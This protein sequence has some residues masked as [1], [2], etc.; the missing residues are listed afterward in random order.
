M[1]SFVV[2]DDK[3]PIESWPLRHAHLIGKESIPVVAKVEVEDGR[4]VCRKPTADEAALSLQFDAGP[5]G[6]LTLQTCLL[7]DR[8]R[9]Y[10]LELELAR[11]RIM[12][13]LNKLEEWSLADLPGDHPV[14]VKFD[15]AR[16][17]FSA[18]LTSPQTD[19]KYDVEHARLAREALTRAI[20][21]SEML[22]MLQAERQLAS[23]LNPEDDARHISSPRVGSIV[24]ND[25]F[26]DP[27]KRVVASHFDFITSPMRWRDIEKEEG[28]FSFGE[29]DRWIE[30]AVRSGKV[31]LTG[32][33]VLDFSPRATPDWLY[34]W[35]HDYSSLREFAYEHAKRVVTRYRRT[36][37]RWSVISGVNLN[38][39]FA[40]SIDQMLELTRL[41]VLLV[42]KLH[43]S[44][45]VVVELTQ[46]FGEHASANAQSV[47][48]LLYAELVMESG[49]QIDAFGLRLQF[50]DRTEG[51]STRDLMQFSAILD[52]YSVFEKPIDITAVGV[53]SEP[54]PKPDD[55]EIDMSPGWWHA[56]WSLELQSE[57]MTEA[58]TIA[59]GKPFVR[60]FCWQALF[61]TDD[62]PEM[63]SGALITADGRA[64]PVLK[65]IGEGRRA[66]RNK[67]LPKDATDTPDEPTPP[68]PAAK[69]DDD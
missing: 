53:P 57:W 60:S 31:S 66:L 39:G 34:I 62:G 38:E 12:L 28:K 8:D 9:P 37:S 22:S 27:L 58:L 16:S 48:P 67:Q 30:W 29:T 63:P 25:Q 47:A 59:M 24:H 43:P 55:E 11:H 35:E 18:A 36:I 33:P 14:M 40:F 44:A 69:D 23:R 65:R 7:P 45:K 3:G 50:G 20:E 64:K 15:E 13:F 46:P 2:F 26:S 52:T 17:S 32:G 21:A 1:L 4:I 19:C 49:I 42:R 68:T 51:R 5:P 56:D 41:A 54:V 61:D 6:V 10:L